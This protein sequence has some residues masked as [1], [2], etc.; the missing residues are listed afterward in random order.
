MTTAAMKRYREK[1][2]NKIKEISKRSHIKNKNR[3]RRQD[4]ERYNEIKEIILSKKNDDEVV[5]FIHRILKVVEMDKSIARKTN[6]CGHTF[7]KVGVL[8]YA[9]C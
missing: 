3:K 1:N 5:D 7:V 6:I 4:K 2:I 9:D 8:H